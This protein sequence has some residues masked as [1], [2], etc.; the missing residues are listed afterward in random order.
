MVIFKCLYL[1]KEKGSCLILKIVEMAQI[2]PTKRSGPYYILS[3]SDSQNIPTVQV[4]LIV[5]W[6][7]SH[8]STPYTRPRL[9]RGNV[10]QA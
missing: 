1:Y 2:R 5:D 4:P 8:M 10:Q 3:Q 6:D 9:V 7:L